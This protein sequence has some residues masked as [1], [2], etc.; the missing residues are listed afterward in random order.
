MTETLVATCT[1]GAEA[2]LAGELF[3]ILGE[4][5]F[6]VVA[7]AVTWE[8][9]VADGYRACLHSRVASRVLLRLARF[10]CP[11][12]DALLEGVVAID[13]PSHLRST[14]RL[15][16]DFVGVSESIRN[17]R[18][19]AMRTKDGVVDCFAAKGLARPSVDLKRPDIRINVHLRN[20]VAA[21]A[22]DLSGTALHI[23]GGRQAGDAPIK[24]TLAAAILRIADWP[25]KA[26]QG[27][28]LVDPMCGSGTLLLEAAGMAL[29]MPPG[30]VRKRWG[31]SHWGG[32]D[33]ALWDEIVA[34][35]REQVRAALKR[36]VSL[37]GAD[38]DGSV[39]SLAQS[40]A[41]TAGLPI[42]F[43][44]RSLLDCAAPDG[45]P[46]LVVTNPPYGERLLSFR[47]AMQLHADLGDVLRHR[48]L[49]W[50]AW[51]ITGGPKLAK[52]IGLRADSRHVLHNGPIECRLLQYGI[53]SEPVTG[54]G[55]G[56][57]H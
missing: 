41:E 28:P 20:D 34:E 27:A 22:I 3:E 26:R 39:L 23:R 12:S 53:S 50:E 7:G 25:A 48:F 21:V 44:R 57:R 35:G 42:K 49:G 17:S 5:D 11:D 43:A 16:V 8:G 4:R 32:H 56:W 36:R 9:P 30:L 2:P 47:D 46:G 24:E 6:D 51:I 52:A 55:P 37:Y 14:G 13:W 54:R 1:R 10:A 31:F 40:N 19:G 15:A 45:P 18:F 38:L 29:D 33:E